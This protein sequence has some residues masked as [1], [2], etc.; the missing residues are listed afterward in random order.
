MIVSKLQTAIR[1]PLHGIQPNAH[2]IRCV[3]KP[4][5]TARS[6]SKLNVNKTLKGTEGKETTL[7]PINWAISWLLN[8]HNIKLARTPVMMKARFSVWKK[9]RHAGQL[10][11]LQRSWLLKDVPRY[12]SE[13]WYLQTSKLKWNYRKGLRGP[14][15]G[16]SGK[17]SSKQVRIS[18]LVAH[19][20]L[21]SNR[22]AISGSFSLA[23]ISVITRCKAQSA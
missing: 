4:L 9:G 8:G 20:K 14:N 2:L 11:K 1:H 22:R 5:C 15:R 17:C 23:F 21:T 19:R 3:T 12:N 6:K 16:C 18:W 10:P 7:Y 13:Q